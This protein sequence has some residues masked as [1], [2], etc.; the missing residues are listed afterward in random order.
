MTTSEAMQ[1]VRDHVAVLGQEYGG[2][3]RLVESLTS[4]SSGVDTS[5]IDHQITGNGRFMRP[6]DEVL[7]DMVVEFNEERSQ[8]DEGN[9]FTVGNGLHQSGL[10]RKAHRVV[11]AVLAKALMLLQVRDEFG[12]YDQWQEQ[13]TEAFKAQ[14]K[15]LSRFGWNV[16]MHRLYGSEETH[17]FAPGHFSDRE[18]LKGIIR[19]GDYLSV[20]IGL[21]IPGLIGFRK[22][23]FIRVTKTGF[24]IAGD[25]QRLTQIIGAN[26]YSDIES[27]RQQHIAKID[28]FKTQRDELDKKASEIKIGEDSSAEAVK[29]DSE[30]VKDL[31]KKYADLAKE[32]A[33]LGKAKEAKE[34][35]DKIKELI[36]AAQRAEIS[37]AMSSAPKESIGNVTAALQKSPMFSKGVNLGTDEVEVVFKTGNVGMDVE[38]MTDGGKTKYT[39]TVFGGILDQKGRLTDLGKFNIYWESACIAADKDRVANVGTIENEV[40]AG[41]R[42]IRFLAEGDRKLASRLAAEGNGVL[43]GVVDAANARGANISGLDISYLASMPESVLR[44]DVRRSLEAPANNTGASSGT[45]SSPVKGGIASSPVLA[46]APRND[47]DA[48]AINGAPTDVL[49]GV[50]GAAI[51]AM[52]P[53]ARVVSSSPILAVQANHSIYDIDN[54]SWLNG[55][56]E[57]PRRLR[58][59]YRQ[60]HMGRLADRFIAVQETARSLGLANLPERASITMYGDLALAQVADRELEI[61]IGAL[62]NLSTP[63]LDMA[64]GHETGHVAQVDLYERKYFADSQEEA[65]RL[66]EFYRG[67]EFTSD[68]VA[69]A[70]VLSLHGREAVLPALRELI[71]AAKGLDVGRTPLPGWAS[72]YAQTGFVVQTHPADEERI[73][74]LSSGVVA[75]PAS[76]I[77]ASSPV[78]NEIASSPIFRGQRH[79]TSEVSA[80]M[81]HPTS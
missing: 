14:D 1:F 28:G 36:V 49:A 21:Y 80:S 16:K 63:A 42:V 26:A 15:G 18:Q 58:E 70:V 4:L 29:D 69:G 43:Q 30:K 68:F 65:D 55:Y 54:P 9:T 71:E 3:A 40:E 73:R 74:A 25:P 50:A 20:E 39:V 53:G 76:L 56:A 13:I 75:I 59:E 67:V 52:V 12:R 7:L 81:Q 23:V 10:Q 79:L 66:G 27:L 11:D 47:V 8:V 35:G 45:T 19:E 34:C 48:G 22:E 64:M 5:V 17:S 51:A 62:R 37:R 32:Y 72:G 33:E 46:I 41:V 61:N 60:L 24:E 57:A 77:I 44:N 6:G 2:E 38:R 78:K 31:I